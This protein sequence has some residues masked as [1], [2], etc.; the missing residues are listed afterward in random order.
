MGPEAARQAV[1]RL[2]TIQLFWNIL[3]IVDGTVILSATGFRGRW[4]S[5]KRF[6]ATSLRLA[7]SR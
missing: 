1:N 5:K 4:G 2:D 6:G 3:R 7:R